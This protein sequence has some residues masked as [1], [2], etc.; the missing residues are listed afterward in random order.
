MFTQA[1]GGVERQ[2]LVGNGAANVLQWIWLQMLQIEG[3]IFSSSLSLLV[4][5]TTGVVLEN[6]LTTVS[7]FLK[8]AHEGVQLCIRDRC[9]EFPKD[10]RASYTFHLNGRIL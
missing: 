4:P 8:L 5:Q 7:V 2:L 10:L 6:A 3:G 9:C 1:V